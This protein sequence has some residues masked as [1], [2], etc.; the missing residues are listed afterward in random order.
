M[1]TEQY[2]SNRNTQKSK[3]ILSRYDLSN[4]LYEFM[5]DTDEHA[6]FTEVCERVIRNPRFY[7]DHL[8][9][10]YVFR[11]SFIRKRRRLK[12]HKAFK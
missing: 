5:S 9:E 7:L 6:Y 1:V 8:D 2:N 4:K 10:L 3:T 12:K 11:V